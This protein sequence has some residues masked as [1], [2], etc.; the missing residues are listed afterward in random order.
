[1]AGQNAKLTLLR[2]IEEHE[3][4][5]GW[6]QFERAIPPG[7]FTDELPMTRAKDLLD[8][9]ESDGLVTTTPGEPQRKYRLTRQGLAAIREGAIGSAPV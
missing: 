6:Y 3:G 7:W 1:M 9:L 8:R 5:W 2:L 4:E